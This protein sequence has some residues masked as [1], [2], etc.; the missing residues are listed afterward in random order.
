MDYLTGNRIQQ[1][2][3]TGARGE[4]IFGRNELGGQRFHRWVDTLLETPDGAL[5]KQFE[6]GLG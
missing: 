2:V 1:N 5:A 4:F 3:K 6:A